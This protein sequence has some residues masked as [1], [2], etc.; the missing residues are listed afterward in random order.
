MK[1]CHAQFHVYLGAS[2][3]WQEMLKLC[4]DLAITRIDAEVRD[5]IL[6]LVEDFARALQP[7]Q[8]REAYEDLQ[9]RWGGMRCCFHA[10]LS[11]LDPQHA[12]CLP[13]LRDVHACI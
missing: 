4:T 1:N 7:Q 11:R 2:E 5:K 10:S 12:C 3:L 6:G 9:V 8:F 13:A